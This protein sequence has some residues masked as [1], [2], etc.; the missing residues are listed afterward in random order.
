MIS[1]LDS[2]INQIKKNAQDIHAF[3]DEIRQCNL[4]RDP[5]LNVDGSLVHCRVNFSSSSC[6]A[7]TNLFVGIFRICGKPS[8]RRRYG[9]TE[10]IQTHRSI[11]H[12]SRR[13]CFQYQ[14]ISIFENENLLCLLG[15]TDIFHAL[16]SKLR[17]F[18]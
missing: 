15:T 3:L 1:K 2:T 11:D 10:E 8:T 17:E 4:F 12:Q 14:Y 16:R 9:I 18:K 7:I 6:I 5:P 13:T